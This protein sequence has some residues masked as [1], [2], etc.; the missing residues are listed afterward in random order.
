M[1]LFIW[2]KNSLTNCSKNIVYFYNLCIF[3]GISS[4]IIYLNQRQTLYIELH[5]R[6]QA[7]CS[8]CEIFRAILSVVSGKWVREARGTKRS[9]ELIR[10]DAYHS[11]REQS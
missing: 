8:G 5:A 6:S 11:V 4:M 9:L 1:S 3:N 2:Y 10:K 7:L